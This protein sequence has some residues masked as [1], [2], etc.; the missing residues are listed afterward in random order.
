MGMALVFSYLTLF[1]EPLRLKKKEKVSYVVVPPPH[2]EMY[3]ELFLLFLLIL[4]I[5]DFELYHLGFEY[6]QPEC[7]LE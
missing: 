4:V 5:F 6:A 3:F 7:T 2:F 1:F